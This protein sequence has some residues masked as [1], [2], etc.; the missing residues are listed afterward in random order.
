MLYEGVPPVVTSIHTQMGMVKN[1]GDICTMRN[2]ICLCDRPMELL[3][4]ILSSL[5]NF[6]YMSIRGVCKC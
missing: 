3:P 5:S 1:I 2:E 4:S 6:D